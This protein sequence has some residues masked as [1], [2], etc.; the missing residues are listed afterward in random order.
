[1]FEMKSF[2]KKQFYEG[3]NIAIVDTRSTISV[4]LNNVA[5]E[6]RHDHWNLKCVIGETMRKVDK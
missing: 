2:Q 3:W 5:L 4:I 6:D 1:M